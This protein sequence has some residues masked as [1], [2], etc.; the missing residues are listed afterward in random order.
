VSD[1]S[2]GNAGDAADRRA[3][4]EVVDRYAKIPDDRN[5]A[6]VDEIFTEDATLLGP[7]FELT[8]RE[9]IRRGMRA[10]EQYTAT[11]HA[12]HQHLVEIDG[13]EATGETW[14]VANHLY[15]KDG[16]PRKLDWG[17]RYRDRYRRVQG[18]WQVAR[19][20]LVLVWT[21]DLPV[22]GE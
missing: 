11:L 1:R 15:E 20:E 2:S 4:R 9:S 3:L 22:R 17:I 5:Y 7:G 19:R 18:T 21:Q 14:C 12:M 10:I 6:L 16:E 13:D 8:G